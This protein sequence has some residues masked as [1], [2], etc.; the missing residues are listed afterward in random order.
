VPFPH[1]QLNTLLLQVVVV[2]VTSLVAVVV[3]E[4]TELPLVYQ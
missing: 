1:Q 2:V 3:L 4:S